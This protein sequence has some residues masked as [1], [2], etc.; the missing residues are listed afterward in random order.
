MGC[1]FLLQR[2]FPDW[3]LNSGFLPWQADSLR[4]AT[5]EAVVLVS[6]L[7]CLLFLLAKVSKYRHILEM[8]Q[9][10]FQAAKMNRISQ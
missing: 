6:G 9:V 4:S 8:V 1:Y 3:G 2:L 7:L 5:R 10:Q